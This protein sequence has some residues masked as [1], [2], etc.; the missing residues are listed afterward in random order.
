[1]RALDGAAIGEDEAGFDQF[2][3]TRAAE[4]RQLRRQKAIETLARAGVCDL[5]LMR[6]YGRHGRIL[7]A[8]LGDKTIG[9]TAL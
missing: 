5:E 4:V 1:L 6:D 9:R 3:N 8:W 7:A 2:L